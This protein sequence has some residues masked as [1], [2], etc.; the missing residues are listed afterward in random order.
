LNDA[1]SNDYHEPD[2]ES[3]KNNDKKNPP[4]RPPLGTRDCDK[5]LKTFDHP[6]L[7]TRHAIRKI[8]PCKIRRN[9]KN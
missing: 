2:G 7:L 3:E 6:Y 5:C 4:G 1:T 8:A 9:Y